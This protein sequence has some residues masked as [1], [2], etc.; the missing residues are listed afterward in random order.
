[1]PHYNGYHYAGVVQ[2]AYA[3]NAPVRV[4]KIDPSRG[5]HGQ[6]PALIS[7]EDRNL[8][9][10][11]VKRAEDGDGIIVRLYECHN[12]RGVAELSCARPIR[13]AVLCDL[14]E[15]EIQDLDLPDGLVRFDYKPFEI[16]TI[17]LRV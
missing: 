1:M 14:E 9:V 11:A 15:G 17:R 5:E 6:L 7:C 10:E 2:A 4:A 13:S 3:L 8:V 12:C 16:I